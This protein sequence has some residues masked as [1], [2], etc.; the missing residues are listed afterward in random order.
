MDRRFLI[1]IM[2]ALPVAAMAQTG[3]VAV[4]PANSEGRMLT[5]EEAVLG[6]G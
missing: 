1:L 5:M 3:V 2:L 6:M 4:H